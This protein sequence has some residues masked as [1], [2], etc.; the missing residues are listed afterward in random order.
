MPR[1][2]REFA[3]LV[4]DAKGKEYQPMHPAKLTFQALRIHLNDEF[5]EMRRGMQA[6]FNLLGERGRIGLIT[7]KHSEC[8]IVMD[9]FRRLEAL[10]SD[11][12]FA[13]WYRQQQMAKSEAARLPQLPADSFALVMDDA[14]RPSERELQANSRSRSAVLHVLRKMHLPK[15]A[16]AEA[17]GYSVLGWAR[18]SDALDGNGDSDG[19]N[20]G[21]GAATGGAGDGGSAS[22]EL[23]KA[24]RKAAKAEKRKREAMAASGLS[25]VAADEEVKRKTEAARRNRAEKK[26]LK[27][28][29]KLASNGGASHGREAEA[30][31]TNA[32]A[33]P[34]AT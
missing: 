11:S 10:R 31:V 32:W 6:A 18:V 4:A 3:S 13:K 20:G 17:L 34:F 2:T 22:R 7:W 15:L 1:R 27:K 8:A 30:D 29:K 9:V 14:T 33:Q 24:E 25:N 19:D 28:Q 5:G 21:R 12:P 16:D 26:E 23:T